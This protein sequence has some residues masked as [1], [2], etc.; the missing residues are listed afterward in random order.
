MTTKRHKIITKRHNTTTKKML[1]CHKETP[2]EP[3][4]N[5]WVVN[6]FTQGYCVGE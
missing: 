1:N 5:L 6:S 2:N 3:S 4:K